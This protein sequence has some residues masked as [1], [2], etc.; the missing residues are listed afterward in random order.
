MIPNPD[1]TAI[2]QAIVDLLLHDPTLAALVPDGVYVDEAPP[3]AQR[4]V[5]VA[6][7]DAQDV[8]VF[9]GRAYEDKRYTIVAKM[10]STAGGDIRSAAAQIDYLLEDVVLEAAGYECMTVYRER[11]IRETDVDDRDPALRW[12]HRGGEYRVQM[13]INDGTH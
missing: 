3:N 7:A 5:I 8:P 1:T 6:L 13:A 2:D 10:L 12:F 4:F 9:G 11:P